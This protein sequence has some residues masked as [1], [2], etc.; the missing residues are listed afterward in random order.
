MNP[1]KLILHLYTL[2]HRL[3]VKRTKENKKLIEAFIK[4]IKKI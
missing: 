2:L 4:L 3:G 1:E